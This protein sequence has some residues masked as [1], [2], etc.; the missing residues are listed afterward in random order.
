MD[1]PTEKLSAHWVL[2]AIQRSQYNSFPDESHPLH[3]HELVVATDMVL[4]VRVRG[5]PGTAATT[6]ATAAKTYLSG[7]QR[8]E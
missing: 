6:T 3:S 4:S 8:F 1:L 2:G 7:E 5:V